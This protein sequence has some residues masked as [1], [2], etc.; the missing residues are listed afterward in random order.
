MKTEVRPGKYVI[1]VSGGVD[2]VV[3]LHMLVRTPEVQLIVAHFDHGIRTDSIEDRRFVAQLAK[4]Y[5]L[6]FIYDEGRLG[7]RA[8]EATAREARYAF[9]QE[10]QK[11]SGAHAIIT[12]H[13]QDDV[14]ETAILNLLRGTGRK[15]L[16]S[17]RSTDSFVRPLLGVPKTELITYAKAHNLKWREDSTNSDET[18]VRNY[19]RHNLVPKLTSKQRKELL[20]YI[21]RM[22]DVNHNIDMEL[23]NHLHMQ[24]ET[25]QLNRR[26]FIQLP[27]SIAKEVLATWLRRAGI[28]DFDSRT[29][30]RIVVGAKTL[31]VGASIDVDVSHKIVVTKSNLALELRDR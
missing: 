27:H 4:A 10:V 6:P 7:N 25:T 26:Y 3:L 15:G 22:H 16:S 13:H 17:L 21:T 19:V 8:S 14:I 5:K 11:K 18:Y 29:L 23:A 12:A 1:A 2:S 9:L 31:D 28:R 20:L 24:P 30:Q